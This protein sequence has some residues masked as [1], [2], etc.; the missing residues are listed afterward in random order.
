MK[1]EINQKPDVW[2]EINSRL[3][4]AAGLLL[5]AIALLVIAFKL[6]A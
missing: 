5:I 4:I 6:A 2:A 3:N 1:H